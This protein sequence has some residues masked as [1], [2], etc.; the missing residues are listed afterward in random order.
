[1]LESYYQLLWTRTSL[2]CR[3]RYDPAVCQV[4][5]TSCWNHEFE[6]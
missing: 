6:P 4:Y 1:M 3:L 2:D 5:A